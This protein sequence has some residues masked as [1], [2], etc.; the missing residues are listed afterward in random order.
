[1]P[2]KL[3]ITVLLMAFAA[4]FT[5][6]NLDNKC[7][8]WLFHVFN[9]VPVYVTIFSSFI[10]G[11]FIMIP[12]TVGKGSRKSEKKSRE[13]GPVKT[14]REKKVSRPEEKSLIGADSSS[15]ASSSSSGNGPVDFTKF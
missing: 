4:V 9:D 12:F 2:I 3:I 5:G 14:K 7:N 1:M 6:F 15:P 11:V 8:I 13:P 10:A